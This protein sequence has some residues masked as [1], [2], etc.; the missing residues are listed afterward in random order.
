MHIVPVGAPRQEL[1]IRPIR[2]LRGGSFPP[3]AADALATTTSASEPA[4]RSERGLRS[5]PSTY[6]A[7][8]TNRR[9]QAR[10]RGRCSSEARSLSTGLTQRLGD[11]GGGVGLGPGPGFGPSAGVGEMAEDA[12]VEADRPEQEREYEDWQAEQAKLDRPTDS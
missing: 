4:S 10:G 2:V 12:E 7:A 6:K 1:G 3:Q 9:E 5:T 8:R 11:A